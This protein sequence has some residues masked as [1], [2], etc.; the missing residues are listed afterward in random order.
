[1]QLVYNKIRIIRY[2]VV[3]I[4]KRNITGFNVE[5]HCER[6]VDNDRI[7]KKDLSKVYLS[8]VYKMEQIEETS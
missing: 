4:E 8:F 5:I 2:E 6:L 7:K 3:W 1:M